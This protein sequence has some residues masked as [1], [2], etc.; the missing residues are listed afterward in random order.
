MVVESRHNSVPIAPCLR[1]F[2]PRVLAVAFAPLLKVNKCEGCDCTAG[3]RRAGNNQR[4]Y[5]TSRKLYEK[6]FGVEVE[7]EAY[8]FRTSYFRLNVL[9]IVIPD[10]DS[11]IL[12][13]AVGKIA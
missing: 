8:S 5:Q 2:R 6:V 13:F 7:I 9:A 1:C 10:I 12:S 3:G 11:F 4:F